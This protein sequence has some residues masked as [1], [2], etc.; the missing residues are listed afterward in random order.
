MSL[1]RNLSLKRW[2]LSSARV[3]TDQAD[4]RRED[5]M[6]GKHPASPGVFVCGDELTWER[7]AGEVGENGV[8][9]HWWSFGGLTFNPKVRVLKVRDIASIVV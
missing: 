4:G 7:M 2:D 3:G 9:G 8:D 5:K 6:V 1:E